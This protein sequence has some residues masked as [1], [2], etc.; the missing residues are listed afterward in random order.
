MK[1]YVIETGQSK[2]TI[3]SKTKINEKLHLMANGSIKIEYKNIIYEQT[4]SAIDEYQ[5]QDFR[6]R[7]CVPL[8]VSCPH[9]T[10]AN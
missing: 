6:I 1:E 5:I 4:M 8:L 10:A 3:E 7:D 2:E 9:A